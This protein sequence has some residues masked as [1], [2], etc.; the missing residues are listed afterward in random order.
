MK[1]KVQSSKFKIITQNLKFYTMLSA[2]PFLF[3]VLFGCASIKEGVRGI[4]GISTKSLEEARNTAVTQTFK[5]DYNNCYNKTIEILR[6]MHAY[7]Y[8]KNPKKDLIAVYVSAEDTTPVGIFFKKIDEN[9]TQ[10][11]VSSPSAYAKE[12]IATKLFPDLVIS[13]NPEKGEEKNK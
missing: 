10:I 8:A 7:I 9:N 5:G 12:H 4:L 2:L 6:D 11:E 3:F 1:L 13:L